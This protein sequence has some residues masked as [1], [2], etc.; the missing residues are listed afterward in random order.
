MRIRTT[1]GKLIDS[2]RTAQ[3]N[4]ADATCFIGKV[5]Y[6]G[7]ARLKNFARTI[8]KDGITARAIV[9]DSLSNAM[10]TDTSARFV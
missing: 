6:R 5:D 4:W 8:F 7:E 9:R 10:P 1:V 2:L 3:A